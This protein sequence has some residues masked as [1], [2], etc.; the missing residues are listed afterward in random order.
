MSCINC[1]VATG[2]HHKKA[3]PFG[4]RPLRRWWLTGVLVSSGLSHCYLPAWFHMV[5]YTWNVITFCPP[6]NPDRAYLKGVLRMIGMRS[7]E[8]YATA[9]AYHRV[10]VEGPTTPPHWQVP[11]WIP[12]PA[13]PALAF[14]EKA[15]VFVDCGQIWVPF[16]SLMLF[17]HYGYWRLDNQSILGRNWG[18]EMNIN[19]SVQRQSQVKKRMLSKAKDWEQRNNVRNSHIC[20]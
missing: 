18:L 3:R 13:F 11:Q 19:L 9:G 20:K 6:L 15:G 17:F 4:L 14:P 7:D 2:A 12:L 10:C 5:K 1:V 16:L 8:C